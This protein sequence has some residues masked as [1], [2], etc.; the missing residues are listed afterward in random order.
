MAQMIG[1]MLFLAQQD[2]G[3]NRREMAAVDL[4]AEVRSHFDYYEGWAEERGVSLALEGTAEIAG[5]RLLLQRALGNLL[6][7]AIRHTPGGG[8]VRVTLGADADGVAIGVANPGAAIP[9][10]ALPKIFDR[11]FRVDPSR[12]RSGEG[13]GLGLAIVKSIVDVHR[14][15]IGVESDERGTR[16]RIHLPAAGVIE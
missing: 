1:D 13:A 10:A 12:Q 14:G 9:P 5:D 4:V 7:N 11:F 2:N 3:G 16:F 6:S 15:L 8:E